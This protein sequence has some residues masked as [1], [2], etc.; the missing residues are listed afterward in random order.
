MPVL[1]LVLGDRPEL[2]AVTM[3]D[4]AEPSTHFRSS[5]PRPV[6]FLAALRHPAQ[7]LRPA[8]LARLSEGQMQAVEERAVALRQGEVDAALG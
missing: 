8:H 1:V 7:V 4:V 5:K 3:A 6:L 2:I